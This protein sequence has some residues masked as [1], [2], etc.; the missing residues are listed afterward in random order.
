M[1][2]GCIG[3]AAQINELDRMLA[4]AGFVEIRM[5]AREDSAELVSGWVRGNTTA[6][7]IASFII[8]AKH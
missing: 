1:I 3:G 8:E 2:S 7:Y 5:E 6:S 4:A